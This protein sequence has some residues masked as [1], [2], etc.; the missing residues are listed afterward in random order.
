DNAELYANPI[1]EGLGYS[2]HSGMAEDASVHSQLGFDFGVRVM[3]AWVPDERKTFEPALPDV[4]YDNTTYSGS[5]NLQP[6]GGGPRITPTA[7]GVGDGIIFEPTP[8]GDYAQAISA[9]GGDPSDP[10]YRIPFPE[11][12]DLS[13]VPFVVLQA[14]VGLGFNTEL[15]ARAI[16]SVE[17]SGDVGE[18]S[19]FGLGVKHEVGGWFPTPLPVD[20]SLT[21]GYQ[22]LSVGDYMDASSTAFGLLVGRG[23][24]PLAAFATVENVNPSIDV[25]YTV[26]NPDLPIDGQQISFSPDLG[27]ETR[28]GVGVNMTFLLVNVS[29]LYTLGDYNVAS[30]KAGVSFR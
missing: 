23:L 8:G 20:V 26:D 12:Q 21:A 16:P 10:Q 24:G 2:L 18:V 7:A 30:V 9:T 1:A 5:A 29:A 22:G 28:V 14:G 15:T 19:A 11:G 6:V 4:E 3:G 27:S 17:P 25:D 13:V